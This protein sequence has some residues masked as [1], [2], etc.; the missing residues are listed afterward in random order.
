M[1]VLIFL[2]QFSVLKWYSHRLYLDISETDLERFQDLNYITNPIVTPR[3]AIAAEEF[4]SMTSI[5][6]DIT[7]RPKFLS[8]RE[9]PTEDIFIEGKRV[10][11]THLK[12]ERSPI[13]RRLFFQ[14]YPNTICDMCNCNTQEKYP[15][16]G[17]LL[18]MH[19]I[20][21]LSSTLAITTSGTS[22]DDIVAL[23]PTC[24]RAT[25]DYYKS[26]LNSHTCD[27]FQ[28]KEQASQVYNEAKGRIRL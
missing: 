15:W 12:V 8:I 9:I 23:C 1:S 19:H 14:E 27:D 16:T 7:D 10:R 22:L 3:K 17:N 5:S 26:W 6:T 28:T 13:L 18:E 20:L 25:H 4:L 11:V 2:S 24:H 21:P